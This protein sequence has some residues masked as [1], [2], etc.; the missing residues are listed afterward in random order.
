MQEV[1]LE[2]IELSED[3]LD[4]VAGGGGGCGGCGCGPD[5]ALAA[6][7]AVAV[8]TCG[9][10]I[11]AAG[12]VAIAV[13]CDHVE[14][15]ARVIGADPGVR[16]IAEELRRPRVAIRDFGPLAPAGGQP[17][18]EEERQRIPHAPCWSQ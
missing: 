15:R 9:F 17:V 1:L 12:A 8:S 10:N 6:A 16:Q 18:I 2:P 5:L 4:V 3:E 7:A 13:V 14:H 11:A